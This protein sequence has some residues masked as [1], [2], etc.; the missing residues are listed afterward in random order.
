MTHLRVNPHSLAFVALAF[1]LAIPSLMFWPVDTLY[2]RDKEGRLVLRATM[3]LG[4]QFETQYLHS[5]QLSLVEDLYF[6]RN[7]LF[8]EWQGRVK[9]QSAGL[10][11]LP[12]ERG[13][14]RADLPWMVFEG[15]VMTMPSY[16]LR[17]GTE[18]LG[19]NYLRVGNGAWVPLYTH[20]PGERLYMETAR[21]ALYA[22]T[23]VVARGNLPIR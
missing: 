10:P 12:V 9:A 11:C 19:Q 17:V 6:V 21:H 1:L 14:F 7:G 16:V 23:E 8:R 18:K 13:R 5:V 2:A 20:F 22:D 4:R 15:A 3:P